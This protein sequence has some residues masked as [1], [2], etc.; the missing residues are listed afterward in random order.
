MRMLHST[1][2][3][4]FCF[5]LVFGLF[6]VFISA[7]CFFF[8]LL[9]TDPIIRYLVRVK[10]TCNNTAFL[11]LLVCFFFLLFFVSSSSSA[12]G[13]NGNESDESEFEEV[14][15]VGHEERLK[16]KILLQLIKNMAKRKPRVVS[17]VWRGLRI[18]IYLLL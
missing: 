18:F 15:S 3:F 4:F 6:F 9:P 2:F 11:V 14:N 8:Q 10:S 7:D 16:L 12:D 13:G 17:C 1:A 5:L